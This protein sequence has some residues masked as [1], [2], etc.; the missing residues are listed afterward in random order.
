MSVWIKGAALHGAALFLLAQSAALVEKSERAKLWMAQ[1][2]FADAAGLYEELSRAAPGNPGLL[3]NLGM[4][5]H[6]AGN[7]AGAVAPLEAALRIQAIPPAL[8]FL[9]S[10]YMH[11]GQPAKAFAPLRRFVSLQPDHREARQMLIEAATA[12]GNHLEAAAQL[13]KVAEEESGQPALLY[14]L[15]R[16][17]QAVSAGEMSKLPEDSGYWLALAADGRNKV[18]Q[19]RAGFLLYRKAIEKLPR[20]RGLHAALAGIYRTTGH[21]DW[22]RVEDASEAS[23]GAPAC[24]PAPTLE[25]HFA[26]GRHRQILA[27]PA[28]APEARY[29]KA[30]AARALAREAFGKLAALGPSAV[31]HRYEAESRRDEG[32]NPEAV[33]AWR[34]AA[35]LAPADRALQ[36]ELATALLQTKDFEAAQEIVTALLAEDAP[37]PEF[38]HLQGEI[39]VAQQQPEPAL[40]FL[41]K[42][43]AAEA[44]NLPARAAYGR[45]LIL[46]GRAADAV[47]H[48]EAALPLDTD[49]SLHFQLARAYQ[50]AGKAEL[51]KQTLAKVQAIR[52]REETDR[53]KI[54]AEAEITAPP[55]APSPAAPARR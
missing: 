45:A 43:V 40:P 22:A 30:R 25:C 13:A 23:L 21:E 33:E 34:A 24:Q 49:A 26:A 12:T 15:G 32:R 19:S 28:I 8:L 46:A 2:R 37:A 11:L 42:A 5:R 4:A 6:M 17:W 51:A 54:E 53:R 55:P 9:G 29:W 10:A 16:S 3:L 44:R 52:A 18:R 38:N 50:A 47:P 31:F 27:S 41:E 35:E 48:L 1:G 20:Q 36:F 39:L 14:S 7:D